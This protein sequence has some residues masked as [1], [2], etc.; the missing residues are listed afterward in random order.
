MKRCDVAI[1]GAGHNALVCAIFLARAGLDV[2]VLERSNTVGGAARTEFPFEKAPQLAQSTGAYL[3]GLMPPELVE[4]LGLEFP[5]IR[6]DPHYFLPTLEDRYLTFGSNAENTRAQFETHFSVADWK[7]NR[8]LDTE[9]SALREDMAPSWLEAPL[10][11]EATADRYIRPELRQVFVDLCRGNIGDYLDRFDF[12]D[13]LIPTM[14]AVTDAFSG[15][16]SCFDTPGGGH[17]FMVHN[18]CRL[19]GSDG[20]WMVVAGGMGT[21]TRML[22]DEAR[23]C[24]ATILTNAEVRKIEAD[25]DG[26][27]LDTTPETHASVVVGGCDPFTLRDLV[28][29]YDEEFDRRFDDWEI[30]GTTMKVNLALSG[31]PEF[32]CV[33][34]DKLEPHQGTMHILP[35]GDTHAEIQ[36]AFDEVCAGR[37]ADFPTIEWYIHSTIDESL[38]DP[39]GNHSSALFVQWVPR[40]FEDGSS[41]DSEKADQYASHLIEV[42]ARFAPNLPDLVVDTQVLHPDAIEA[43]FGIHNGHIHHIDNRFGFADRHPYRTPREGLYACSAGCHPAGSVIGAAGHNAAMAVLED[44]ELP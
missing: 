1:V 16:F 6:R 24:G 27:L 5:F 21:V 43:R 26:Y 4:T 13:P 25:G 14:Y 10:S 42:C 41:W 37:L 30:D 20:T 23:R 2:C 29:G 11:I 34:D 28:G 9:L 35:Q 8:A 19:P 18:M 15:S 40:R 12:H 3:V 31:L 38:A 17:N 7:A 33:T 39:D 44:M 36:R 22:A 32:T